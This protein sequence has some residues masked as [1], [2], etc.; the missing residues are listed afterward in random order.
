M[1]FVVDSFLMVFLVLV[2]SWLGRLMLILVGLLLV[3]ISRIF[4][5]FGCLVSSWLVW[6]SVV[7]MWV[8]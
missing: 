4:L 7:F 8:D 6:C 1:M 3:S 2:C 5:L